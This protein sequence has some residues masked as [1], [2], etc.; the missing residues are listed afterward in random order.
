MTYAVC[1]PHIH[2]F[3]STAVFSP[4]FLVVQAHVFTT[5]QTLDSHHSTKSAQ[6][7]MD[8]HKI[9]TD[10]EGVSNAL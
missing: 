9:D 8:I 4:E 5:R 10:G 7:I 6:S 1:L 3:F 2:Y